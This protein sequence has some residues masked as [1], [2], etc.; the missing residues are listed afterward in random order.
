[1]LSSDFT[2]RNQLIFYDANC[3]ARYWDRGISRLLIFV[4]DDARSRQE[5][6]QPR[7]AECDRS[8]TSNSI[9]QYLGAQIN[10]AEQ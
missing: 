4:P 8:T 7:P 6:Y 10:P 9:D 3:F 2:I 1:M 5:Y